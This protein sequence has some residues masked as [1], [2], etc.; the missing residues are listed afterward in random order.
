MLKVP[1]P[2]KIFEDLKTSISKYLDR[3][4]IIISPGI[5]IT[6]LFVTLPMIELRK[7]YLFIEFIYRSQ[8][9]VSV[10]ELL[11][12]SDFRDEFCKA[13]GITESEY[14][15]FL[16][17]EVIR[18]AFPAR[19]LEGTPAYILGKIIVTGAE[20][21]IKIYPDSITLKVSGKVFTPAVPSSGIEFSVL[22]DENSRY[23]QVPFISEEVGI[24]ISDVVNVGSTYPITLNVGLSLSNYLSVL[25]LIDGL[26]EESIESFIDRV[27]IFTRYTSEISLDS[28]LSAILSTVKVEDY[29]IVYPL[30][31]Y[32]SPRLSGVDV[33]VKVPFIEV[34]ISSFGFSIGPKAKSQFDKILREEVYGGS[35]Y[36]VPLDLRI[37]PL[38]FRIQSFLESNTLF[39]N[40]VLGILIKKA[41][42]IYI[43]KIRLSGLNL[44]N[45]FYLDTFL[46]D[47]KKEIYNYLRNRKIGEHITSSDILRVIL[48]NDLVDDCESVTFEEYS[49]A[50]FDGS[51]YS[52]DNNPLGERFTGSVIRPD[53][54]S[55]Y[56]SCVRFDLFEI[57]AI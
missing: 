49:D 15:L 34:P 3:S 22:N 39:Y 27:N 44:K 47:I 24:S 46:E 25:D 28:V 14:E 20:T 48:A 2:E 45:D 11:N 42:G 6:D 17:D 5:P 32:F 4:D 16:R 12:D 50:S 7:L 56:V 36:D 10:L 57:E 54:V 51:V 41:D 43:K 37:N 31:P 9:P 8:N 33:W 19:P 40:N 55:Q 35:I 21:S 18:R 13:F 38:I 30:S 29:K 53:P 1:S 23:I 52:L 26:P